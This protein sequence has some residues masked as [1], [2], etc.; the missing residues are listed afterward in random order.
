MDD[1]A[2]HAYIEQ[3]GQETFQRAENAMKASRA[4]R[5][6]FCAMNQVHED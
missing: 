1:M 5:L 4:S 6:A 3:F 2:G